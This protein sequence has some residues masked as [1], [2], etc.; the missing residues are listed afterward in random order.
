MMQLLPNNL[1]IDYMAW[2]KPAVILSALL[3]LI[4][5]GSLIFRGLNLA[6]DFTGG[7]LVQVAYPEPVELAT[8]RD[9]LAGSEFAEGVVQRFG[10]PREVLIRLPPQGERTDDTVSN[11]LLETLQAAPGG[12]GVQLQRVEFV[13]PQVGEEL[14][15]KGGLGLLV[16]LV[17][18]LIYV[19]LRF[20][21]RLAVG[22]I[23]A[24]AHDAII[25]VGV[26]SV[27]QIEFDL[28]VLAA[29]LAVI[30]YSLND[31]IVV[32]DRVRENFRKLRRESTIEVVNISVNET[33]TRTLMTAGTT[34][35]VLLSLFFL[36]G[37][38]LYGFSLALIV[39]VLIGTYSTIYVATAV[40]LGLGVSKQDLMPVKK[41]GAE[42]EGRP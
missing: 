31:T 4:S 2:R 38:V 23:A 33:M 41:E 12:A 36:G 39:G 5:I 14:T 17:G 10:T 20:E 7:T 29:V 42:V 13:G 40:A 26:F 19:A 3:V 21:Y 37:D 24:T 34:V 6:V 22:A 25:A 11:Q 30:G 28:T 9:A 15:E 16:A 1:R 18:I 35:M 8:V 27:F 32:F